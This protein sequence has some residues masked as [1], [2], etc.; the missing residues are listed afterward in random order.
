MPLDIPPAAVYALLLA[1]VLSALGMWRELAVLKEVVAALGH[2][3]GSVVDKIA[4]DDD[5]CIATHMT[6]ADRL[7]RL[8]ARG[9]GEQGEPGGRGERG[10][11]RED[12]EGAL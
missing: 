8:E 1:V 6:I 2:K 12:A 9:P 11:R 7:A 4:E 3:L 10:L 5:H